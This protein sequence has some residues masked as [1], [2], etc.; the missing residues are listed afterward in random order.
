VAAG[1]AEELK[2]RVGGEVIELRN[3]ADEV[4]RSMP[5]DGSVQDVRR[6]LNELAQQCPPDARIVIRKPSMDDV[7][8]ALTAEQQPY[9]EVSYA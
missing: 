8:L 1:T 7:F 6:L 2:A 5:T 9:Q 3:N 4:I